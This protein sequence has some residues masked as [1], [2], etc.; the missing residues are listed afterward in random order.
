[1]YTNKKKQIYKKFNLNEFINENC[2]N[3]TFNDFFEDVD[4]EDDYEV[5]FDYASKNSNYFYKYINNLKHIFKEDSLLKIKENKTA[6]IDCNEVYLDLNIEDFNNGI[7]SVWLKD[8]FIEGNKNNLNISVSIKYK[9]FN[10]KK[11]EKMSIIIENPFLNLNK[12]YQEIKNHYE[13]NPDFIKNIFKNEH[14]VDFIQRRMQKFLTIP[15]WCETIEDRFLFYFINQL[16]LSQDV[17]NLFGIE[18]LVKDKDTLKIFKT[19]IV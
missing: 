7:S 2:L 16:S 6:V 13:F 10:F 15:N 19:Y 1:M 18:N 3:P 12:K 14:K 8:I 4:Y 11:I 9:D 17:I 5:V